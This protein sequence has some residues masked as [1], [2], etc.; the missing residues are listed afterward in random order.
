MVEGVFPSRAQHCIARI[1][2]ICVVLFLF[3]FSSNSLWRPP[4]GMGT[5][6]S[7]E[8]GVEGSRGGKPKPEAGRGARR[9]G[10]KRG[11]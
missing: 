9:E 3:F 1:S 8:T 6:A 2:V 4:S 7:T 5:F 10:Q 11:N